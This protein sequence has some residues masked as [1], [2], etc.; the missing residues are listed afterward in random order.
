MNRFIIGALS[1]ALWTPT[2]STSDAGLAP[3]IAAVGP[4]WIS[5]EHPANPYD[6]TTKGAYLVVHAFHHGT[7][8]DFPVSGT[9][10][11]IVNGQ[12]RSVSLE[13]ERTSRPGA[14]ALDRQ[15][16]NEGTWTL[17][18]GVAQGRDDRVFAVVD[19]ARSGEVASV[20]VPTRKLAGESVPLPAP[21]AM[22]EIDASLRTRAAQVAGR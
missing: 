22:S 5:I 10:E 13:F 11:G 16:P 4:P 18:I 17:V 6:Q 9:A 12:R 21:V 1:A 7:P 8:V 14:Y 2:A 3:A 20:R 15:W 19:I